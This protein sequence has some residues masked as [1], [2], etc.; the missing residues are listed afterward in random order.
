MPNKITLNAKTWRRAEAAM[1]VGCGPGSERSLKSEIEY[2][3]AIRGL[4]P[5]LRFCGREMT[6]GPRA[7]K[8]LYGD[9]PTLA[10]EI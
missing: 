1:D 3:G 7:G 2:A 8:I 4:C 6:F 9:H 10:Q 5:P